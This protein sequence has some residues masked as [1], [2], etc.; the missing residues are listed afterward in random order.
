MRR[1]NLSFKSLPKKFS[2]SG[3]PGS[4]G[5][6]FGG[7][8]WS[9]VGTECGGGGLPSGPGCLG[10]GLPAGPGCSGGG[11]PA[12]PGGEGGGASVDTECDE[13]GLSAG[14]GCGG[15]SSGDPGCDPVSNVG[16]EVAVSESDDIDAVLSELIVFHSVSR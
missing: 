6:A 14:P 4:C 10:G 9:V 8:W 16:L 15:G 1:L 5:S 12:G 13:G 7:E 2:D 3:A 11:L